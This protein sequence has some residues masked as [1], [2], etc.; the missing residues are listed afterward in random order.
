MFDN[1]SLSTDASIENC[2]K[3]KQIMQFSNK[4]A[5]APVFA[6]MQTSA[7]D[8]SGN[9]PWSET[10]KTTLARFVRYVSSSRPSSLFGIK[11]RTRLSFSIGT[12]SL[13]Q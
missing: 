2:Y 1:V 6:K 3:Q 5:S 7:R 8:S 9:L 12:H 13:E 4:S 10:G 11:Q